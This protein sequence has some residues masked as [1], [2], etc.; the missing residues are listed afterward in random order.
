MKLQLL[1]I[2][3]LLGFVGCTGGMVG[4]AG[5][6]GEATADIKSDASTAKR[7]THRPLK[8]PVERIT[9]PTMQNALGG[10]PAPQPNA[11]TTAPQPNLTYRGGPVLQSTQIYAVLWGTTVASNVKAGLSGFYTDITA[12]GSRSTRCSPSTTPTA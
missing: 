6:A 9:R 11:T 12:A 10:A 2:V 4:N 3:S 5:G 8:T 7:Q 1:S